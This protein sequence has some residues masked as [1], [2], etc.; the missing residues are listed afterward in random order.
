M[1]ACRW[2]PDGDAVSGL[3]V[4]LLPATKTYA[5]PQGQMDRRTDPPCVRFCGPKCADAEH[6][7]RICL[8]AFESKSG[9]L[10]IQENVAFLFVSVG[11]FFYLLLFY[12]CFSVFNNI[13]N[14]GEARHLR[15]SSYLIKV[16]PQPTSGSLL[17][18][19]SCCADPPDFYCKRLGVALTQPLRRPRRK[20]S[21]NNSALVRRGKSALR[22]VTSRL[23]E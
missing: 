3:L 6:T 9:S 11:F 15:N 19:A 4:L 10:K 17:H 14:F 21:A 23:P 20:F 2:S 16:A 13:L 18:S 12:C 7:N 22:F 8:L 5:P 1:Q